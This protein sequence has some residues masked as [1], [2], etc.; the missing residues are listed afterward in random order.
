[1]RSV[2]RFLR[3]RSQAVTVPRRVALLGS[4]LLTM[5]M[6]SRLPATASATICSAAPSAYIS[7]VSIRVMPSSIPACRAATSSLRREAL[8]PIRH[9]PSPKTGTASPEG[10]F[11][12]GTGAAWGGINGSV[13]GTSAHGSDGGRTAPRASNGAGPIAG[14]PLAVRGKTR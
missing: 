6:P 3:L 2:F 12:V 13:S 1:M 7:A 8:S 9:V 10:S 5:N 4:T 11:V 14:F